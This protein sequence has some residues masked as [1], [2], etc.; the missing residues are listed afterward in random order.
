MDFPAPDLSE[1]LK[2]QPCFFYEIVCIS[3]PFKA[4]L[5]MGF[6]WADRSMGMVKP[7][8][9]CE[10]S[11]ACLG[12]I[13]SKRLVYVAPEKASDTLTGGGRGLKTAGV[14]QM[15]V[16]ESLSKET[17]RAKAQDH[18]T[19]WGIQTL[20]TVQ[21]GGP[22]AVSGRGRRWSVEKCCSLNMEPAW[23]FVLGL[24]LDLGKVSWER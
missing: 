5:K 22:R 15:G 11:G 6:W 23:D 7:K 16:S 17:A 18:K 20:E 1:D 9:A 13:H 19:A 4:S 12:Y 14:C 21:G 3:C 2:S 8:V 24:E 10:I